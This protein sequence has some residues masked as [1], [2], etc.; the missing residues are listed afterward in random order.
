MY[1]EG[2]GVSQDNAE[3]AKWF[4]KAAEQ[5]NAKAQ[6]NLGMMF[7][8]GKGVSQDD[9]EAIKWLSMAAGNVEPFALNH[10]GKMHANGEGVE[11][12]YVVAYAFFKFAIDFGYEAAQKSF[13]TLSEKMTSAQITEAE[14]ILRG[15]GIAF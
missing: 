7:F 5:G 11:Q 9:D 14:K 13:E 2:R 3:A 8:Q 15:E 6:C 4:G 1:I 12:N 10:L